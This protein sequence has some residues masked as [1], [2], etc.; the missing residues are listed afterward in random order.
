MDRSR[1]DIE[2]ATLTTLI[3]Y[4]FRFSPDRVAGPDW[5]LGLGSPKFDIAATLPR[6]AS[7]NQTPEMV[8]ALL[9]DRFKLAIHRGTTEQAIYALVVAKGG[10]KMKEAAPEA[11]ALVPAAAADPDAP[12]GTITLFGDVETRTAPNADGSGDTTTISNPRMGKVRWMEGPNLMWSWDAPSIAIEGL[13][14]LLDRVVPLP[15]PVI[16]MTGLKGRYRAVFE[17]SLNDVIGARPPM[18]GAGG[19]PTAIE[20]ARMDRDE[21]VLRAFND[22]LRKLGLQLE[23]RKG[24]LETLIVDHVEKTPTAN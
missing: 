1:V 4:A 22:G 15:S 24:P 12:P 5:M 8:Q 3:G 2:C 9:A 21:M 14:E 17:V 13:A 19:D 18:P 10:L 23:R 11:G 16:D 6:G 7:E 20:N